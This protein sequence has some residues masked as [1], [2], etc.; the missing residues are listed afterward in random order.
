MRRHLGALRA[1]PDFAASL[2]SRGRATIEARHSCAHRVDELLAI[3][4]SLGR[5]FDAPTKL[6]AAQ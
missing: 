4:R 6:A 3:C 5:D 1:D 2:A